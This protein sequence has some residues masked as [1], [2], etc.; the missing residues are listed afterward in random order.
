MIDERFFHKHD[1]RYHF[2]NR[3]QVARTQA[4]TLPNWE[5][6]LEA[7]QNWWK[8]VLPIAIAANVK[9]SEIAKWLKQQLPTEHKPSRYIIAKRI[10]LPSEFL[11]VLDSFEVQ[12]KQWNEAINDSAWYVLGTAIGQ[13]LA[14]TVDIK[15]KLAAYS[16]FETQE[17]GRYA[18][19]YRWLEIL[20]TTTHQKDWFNEIQNAIKEFNP[21]DGFFEHDRELAKAQLAE[22]DKT[23]QLSNT[24]HQS[25]ISLP[26]FSHLIGILD[27][28]RQLDKT[29]YLS[30]LDTLT[31]PILIRQALENYKI[32]PDREE[33]LSLL[34]NAKT[35]L[36]DNGDWNKRTVAPLLA[37]MIVSHARQ[38]VQAVE[39]QLQMPIE[40][41]EILQQIR[42]Q[43]IPDWFNKAFG[44]LLT[45]QDGNV[46]GIK[47]LIELIERYQSEIWRRGETQWSITVT[48]IECLSKCLAEKAYSL[49]ESF[50]ENSEQKG[51]SA[52]LAATVIAEKKTAQSETNNQLWQLFEK[53]LLNGDKGIE[54]HF[55]SEQL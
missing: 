53:L 12:P 24:W 9:D 18:L 14:N 52:F 46:I 41:S 31:Y 45:R 10:S 37:E 6:L 1:F 54:N 34:E 26:F 39:R 20:P 38:L 16:L 7:L 32:M 19:K 47:W 29:H 4:Q 8:A 35:V 51:L 42:E 13:S 50:E 11:S 43:E 30:I 33:I 44:V 21:I 36:D 23:T 22:W 2:E 25:P 3:L 27:L 5:S 28:V 55:Y 17:V 48:A 40:D 49:T 15:H